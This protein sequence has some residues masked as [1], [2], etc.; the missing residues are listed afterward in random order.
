MF[1]DGAAA[2]AGR[3]ADSEVTLDI[4]AP[5]GLVVRTDPGRVRQILDVL[6]DNAL[7]ACP[8]GSRVVWSAAAAR[9]GGVRVEVRDSGPGLAD[10]D[11]LDAFEPGVLHDR[12][13]ADRLGGHGLGLAIAHRLVTRLGGTI[14]LERAPEG[15]AAFVLDLPSR[16]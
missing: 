16:D 13:A 3:C 1:A 11:T 6:T 10:E 12:Y 9:P 4:E 7:R 8:P 15:G 14:R 5:P 2:W